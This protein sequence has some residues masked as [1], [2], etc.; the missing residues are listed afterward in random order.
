MQCQLVVGEVIPLLQNTDVSKN[1]Y[2][3]QEK[4][5]SFATHTHTHTHT[6]TQA[7]TGTHRHTQAHT[8]T[9]THTCRRTHT[10]VFGYVIFDT[11]NPKQLIFAEEAIKSWNVIGFRSY[12]NFQKPS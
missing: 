12:R 9:R 5:C 2:K 7:H 1:D 6:H 3:L 10:Y 8:G 11:Y 4:L